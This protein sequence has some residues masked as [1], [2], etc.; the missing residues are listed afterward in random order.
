MSG[1][2]ERRWA[3]R[4]AGRNAFTVAVHSLPQFLGQGGQ[5]LSGISWRAHGRIVTI[6]GWRMQLPSRSELAAVAVWLWAFL[7]YTTRLPGS[8]GVVLIKWLAT[9]LVD[10]P[11]LPGSSSRM[12]ALILRWVRNRIRFGCAG[13]CCC[14][15][16]P[17]HRDSCTP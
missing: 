5:L 16:L 1:N 17:A 11:R 6:F 12:G 9:T 15:A 2:P 7:H 3:R 14:A 4:G 13:V 8:V 10:L